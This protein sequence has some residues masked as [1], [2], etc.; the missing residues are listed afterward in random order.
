MKRTV[1]LFVFGG[2]CL[3]GCVVKRG[4]PEGVSASAAAVKIVTQK[5]QGCQFLSGV[6][7]AQ[8]DV[9]LDW[10]GDMLDN[11]RSNAAALGG[12]VV[13][14]RSAQPVMENAAEVYAQDFYVNGIQYGG[15]IYK[16]PQN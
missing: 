11:I 15:L 7:G 12:N 5:P 1:C 9:S 14:I 10:K 6:L 16:C 4:Q 13:Y 2:M 3:S 8:E